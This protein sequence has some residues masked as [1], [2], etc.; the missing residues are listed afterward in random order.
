MSWYVCRTKTNS[1]LVA[2]HHLEN[3]GYEV[4][5]PMSLVDKRTGKQRDIE[6]M[7]CG[8]VFVQ[9]QPGRDN[10]HP[11]KSTRGVL[12]MVRFGLWPATVPDDLVSE[13]RRHE[14]AQ[15]LHHIP[16]HDYLPGNV[17]RITGGV[18]DDYLAIVQAKRKDRIIVLI[19]IASRQVKAELRYRDLQPV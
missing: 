14:D 19:D 10:F 17:V 4:Y 16:Q 2:K 3:Q 5:C 8:Y 11:I 6:P 15:G 12:A 7:F 1:E 13:L 9:L 18:F